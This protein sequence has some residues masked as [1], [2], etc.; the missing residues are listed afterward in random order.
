MPS[1]ICDTNKELAVVQGA[2]VKF[3]LKYFV[4]LV[5][6]SEVF[7]LQQLEITSLIITVLG[8][9]AHTFKDI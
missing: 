5:I 1:G 6:I 3:R 7:L 4:L 9:N 8:P 2:C